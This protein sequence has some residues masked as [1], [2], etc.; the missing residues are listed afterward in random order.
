M[1]HHTVWFKS[2]ARDMVEE[3]VQFPLFITLSFRFV[4]L[5]LLALLALLSFTRADVSLRAAHGHRY[6]CVMLR[7]LKK[8]RG[9]SQPKVPQFIAEQPGE[10]WE[11]Y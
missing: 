1:A 8:R 7:P 6:A 5:A 4:L 10:D 3:M 2:W 11:P 9:E